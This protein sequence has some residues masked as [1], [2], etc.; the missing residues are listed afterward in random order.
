MLD[1]S[2]IVMDFIC[3]CSSWCGVE[4]CH[5]RCNCAYVCARVR[6]YMQRHILTYVVSYNVHTHTRTNIH[7]YI[8]VCV[9][10]RGVPW[11]WKVLRDVHVIENINSSRS[12]ACVAA[13]HLGHQGHALSRNSVG[14]TRHLVRN[15]LTG[16]PVQSS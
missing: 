14:T 15:I 12:K 1:T 8:S 5:G 11:Q 10:A 3:S 4:A 9:C 2:I 7:T 16:L 13:L 6:M